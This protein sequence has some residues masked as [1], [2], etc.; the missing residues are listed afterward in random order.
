MIAASNSFAPNSSTPTATLTTNKSILTL[1]ALLIHH[2]F[3]SFSMPL[4]PS[5]STLPCKI[6][7]ERRKISQKKIVAVPSPPPLWHL[8]QYYFGLSKGLLSSFLGI[9]KSRNIPISISVCSFSFRQSS[10]S[11]L[12]F[13]HHRQYASTS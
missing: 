12:R 5:S 7:K 11:A 6:F 3:A 10:L 8:A 2:K 9:V 4:P 13:P 1:L